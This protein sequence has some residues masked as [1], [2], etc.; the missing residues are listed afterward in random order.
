MLFIIITQA[1]KT[2][3][4]ATRTINGTSVLLSMLTS[5]GTLVICKVCGVMSPLAW[6]DWL[7][8]N[9]KRRCHSKYCPPLFCPPRTFFPREYCPLG[10]FPLVNYVPRTFSP[11][12]YCPHP[13]PRTFFTRELCPPFEKNVPPNPYLSCLLSRPDISSTSVTKRLS[14]DLSGRL[15]SYY[16]SGRLTES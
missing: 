14:F 1:E 11:R 8:C 2:D 15:T 12:R 6:V 5:Y 10:H 4:L 9:T 16:Y 13:P 3:V 7:R